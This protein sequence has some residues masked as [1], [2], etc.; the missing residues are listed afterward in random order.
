MRFG[1]RLLAIT[2]SLAVVGFGAFFAII[3]FGAVA[4]GGPDRFA[5]WLAFGLVLVAIGLI[6]LGVVWRR[7]H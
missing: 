3:G 4:L 5:S 7:P 2:W 1:A 6:M